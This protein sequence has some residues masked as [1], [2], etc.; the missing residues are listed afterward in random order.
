MG[1]FGVPR[2]AVHS[3]ANVTSGPACVLS[4]HTQAIRYGMEVM[5]GFIVGFDNDPDDIFDK[6]ASAC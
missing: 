1:Q 4:G 3:V 5:G 6:Q 2:Q